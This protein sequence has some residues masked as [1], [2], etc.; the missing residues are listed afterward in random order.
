MN[1]Q[2]LLRRF[3]NGQRV[4]VVNPTN[5]VMDNKTGTVVRLRMADNAAWVNMDEELPVALQSFPSGDPRSRHVL[6]WPDE[7]EEITETKL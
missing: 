7:C 6:L 4:V 3:T 1:T 5:V 2:R